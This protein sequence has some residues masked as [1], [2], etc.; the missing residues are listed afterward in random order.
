MAMMGDEKLKYQFIVLRG[1]K[2]DAEVLKDAIE[3][4]IAKLS[5]DVEM[6]SKVRNDQAR[7]QR[8]VDGIKTLMGM[9][10]EFMYIGT[11]EIYHPRDFPNPIKHII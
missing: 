5:K 11:D 4:H 7:L 8:A 2:K 1:T 9:R 10:D 6:Y 3:A